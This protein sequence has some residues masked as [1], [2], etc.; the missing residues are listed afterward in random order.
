MKAFDQL[1]T[2]LLSTPLFSQSNIGIFI[3]NLNTNH[4]VLQ[5]LKKFGDNLKGCEF[6]ED[7]VDFPLKEITENKVI[8]EGMIFEKKSTNEMN[9]YVGIR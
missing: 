6:K 8:F 1:L 4:S 7:T 2:A 9:I 5:L 3:L